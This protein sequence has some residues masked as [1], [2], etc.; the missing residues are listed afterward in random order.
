MPSD[1]CC[2]ITRNVF[3]LSI[4]NQTSPSSN[5]ICVDFNI[6]SGVYECPSAMTGL[7]LGIFRTDSECL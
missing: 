6:A 5:P 4:G 7:Y 3:K 2:E 1:H